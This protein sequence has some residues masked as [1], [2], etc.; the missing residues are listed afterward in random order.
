MESY[1]LT[2]NQI[3]GG[4]IELRVDGKEIMLSCEQFEQIRNVLKPALIVQYGNEKYVIDDKSWASQ[5]VH[6][7]VHYAE[8]NDIDIHI[9]KMSEQKGEI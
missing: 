9:V 1:M 6:V 8:Q 2:K 4:A 5:L 3:D 7:L